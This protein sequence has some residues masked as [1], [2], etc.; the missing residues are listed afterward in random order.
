MDIK[1]LLLLVMKFCRDDS[2][3]NINETQLRHEINV[4]LTNINDMKIL[5]ILINNIRICL[6]IQKMILIIQKSIKKN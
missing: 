5:K 3:K 2:K 6:S 1:K 4:I